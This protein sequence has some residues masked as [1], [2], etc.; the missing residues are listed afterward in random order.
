MK[1]MKVML[2]DEVIIRLDSKL[3]AIQ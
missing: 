1:Y 3:V 2:G